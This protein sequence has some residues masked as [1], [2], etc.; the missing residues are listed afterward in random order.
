MQ[1][2]RAEAYEWL[3]C[4]ESDSIDMCLTSPPYDSIRN[5]TGF[6]VNFQAVIAQLY[7]VIKLGGVVIWNVSDQ[8]ISGSETGTSLKQALMFMDSGFKLHD[9]MIYMKNN[10][11]PTSGKRYHQSWEY[12]FCFSKGVPTTFNPIMRECK[13]SHLQANQKYRGTT[14]EL[15]YKKTKRNKFSKVNNVFS[16]T[17]GGGHSTKDK[18]AFSH[19]AIMPEQLALDQVTTWTNKGD[20]VIDP[21]LGS[22]TSAKAAL[23]LEREFMGCDLSQ[24][25]CEIAKQ[26][27]ANHLSTQ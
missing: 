9:T 10:P 22:G 4:I 15:S 18:I 3:S 24:E 27:I 26:R 6:T 19:P 17:I 20:I 2:E 21:F 12:L 1:I 14:G 7:R 11:M 13:Y 25:Y 16:Y 23:M 8:T 5:Y